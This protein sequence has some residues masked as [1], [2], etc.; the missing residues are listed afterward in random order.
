DRTTYYRHD[1]TYGLPPNPHGFLTAA[2]SGQLAFGNI[3]LGAQ[4]QIA[5]FF[6]TDGQVIDPLTDVTNVWG[7]HLFE[8]PIQ[9]PLPEGLNY[10]AYATAGAPAQASGSLASG[11]VPTGPAATSRNGE[12]PE[13][14]LP[15]TPVPAGNPPS[16]TATAATGSTSAAPTMP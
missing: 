11:P 1:L 13:W 9:G 6:A 10:P 8:V 16:P 14:S 7:V 15:A 3:A 12:P 4:R 2:P 5:T